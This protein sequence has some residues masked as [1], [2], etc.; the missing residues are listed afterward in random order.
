MRH[1]TENG[2]TNNY[3]GVR[4]SSTGKRFLIEDATIWNVLDNAGTY[5]GQA[6]MFKT[7][8]YQ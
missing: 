6:A 8:V 7:W 3:S 5:H 2:Y 4:V 1:V